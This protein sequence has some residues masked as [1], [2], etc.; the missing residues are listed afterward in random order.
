VVLL[1]GAERKTK[2]CLKSNK[3]NDTADAYL[4]TQALMLSL[5]CPSSRFFV[6][7]VARFPSKRATPTSLRQGRQ[8]GKRC[9]QQK[10][11]P[12]LDSDGDKDRPANRVKEM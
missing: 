5:V 4:C 7:P 3:T 2:R 1:T 11:P 9:T 6:V 8:G 10:K 12:E